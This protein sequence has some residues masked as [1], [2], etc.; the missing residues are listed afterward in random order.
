MKKT[1]LF[2]AFNFLV[3]GFLLAQDLCSK[4]Y[5]MKD[6]ST[7]QYTSYNKKG[8]VDG[9]HKYAISDVKNTDGETSA[10]FQIEFNNGKGKKEFETKYE[11]TCT[12]TGI[13]IDYMSLMP[14]QMTEQYENMDVEMDF[15]GTDIELP[16]N[17]SVGQEL[18][19]ANVTVNMSISGIAMNISVNIVDRKVEALEQ[20]TTEAGTFDCYQL[21]ETIKSKS[22]GANLEITSKTWLAEGVGMIKNETYKKNGNMQSR[23]EL[24][25]YSK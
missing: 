13:K 9:M 24:T 3:S 22:M 19:D 15:S 2:L 25:A 8:K 21:S 5:P 4:Y 14:A 16:N 12:G 18:N 1:V 10:T 6:G 17:L 7:M 23:S 20:I 11:I